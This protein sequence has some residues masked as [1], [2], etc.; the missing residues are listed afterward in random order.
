[1]YLTFNGF[2]VYDTLSLFMIYFYFSHIEDRSALLVNSY[3][4][5]CICL[6]SGFVFYF[7]RTD[8]FGNK[9]FVTVSAPMGMY[10]DFL[11]EQYPFMEK[12]FKDDSVNDD[13]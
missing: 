1:M 6:I 11:E 13:S 7:D 8:S 2:V 10:C 9:I 12:F 5:L 4:L 3:V